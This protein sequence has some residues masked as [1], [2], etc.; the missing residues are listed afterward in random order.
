MTILK[1]DIMGEQL[2]RSRILDGMKTLS[3]VGDMPGGDVNRG[4]KRVVNA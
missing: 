2:L 3:K 1:Q 4:C